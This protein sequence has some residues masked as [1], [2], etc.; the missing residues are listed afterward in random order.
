MKSRSASWVLYDIASSAYILM[1][2]GV[3]FP[4]Y[5][6]IHVTQNAQWSDAL[7]GALL[8]LSSILAGIV[9]PLVGAAADISGERLRYLTWSTVICSAATVLLSIPDFGLAA[10][11]SL[12]CLSYVAYLV[13]AGLYDALLKGIA[14][15]RSAGWLS[16]LGWG[17]GYLG[18]LLC[19]FLCSALLGSNVGADNS[20]TFALTFLVVGSYYA[21]VGG[22][23]LFG[24]DRKSV[25]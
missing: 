1:I 10:M 2:T 5:F 12:F 9:A 6:K 19:Y 13:A 22:V 17:L 8:A 14:Q 7:W 4:L 3:A 21:V 18:G 20:A 15:G 23:A 25:V 11:A 24:I 16:S